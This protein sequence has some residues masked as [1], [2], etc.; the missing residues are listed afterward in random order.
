MNN[1]FDQLDKKNADELE[2]INSANIMA[3]LNK[4]I[5]L[6]KQD[7]LYDKYNVTLPEASGMREPASTLM[8]PPQQVAS[9]LT[10]NSVN[11]F[12][13]KRKLDEISSSVNTF[14]KPEGNPTPHPTMGGQKSTNTS[15]F[16]A[17]SHLHQTGEMEISDDFQ[18]AVD[19]SR[20]EIDTSSAAVETQNIEQPLKSLQKEA[21]DDW[22]KIK[23]MQ[24]SV[25]PSRDALKVDH[26]Q[27]LQSLDYSLPLN[28]D[29][30]LSFYW[31]DAHEE[32]NGLDLYL[33]G[34]IYQ[35]E[36][37]S[38]VSCALKINGMQREIYALPKTKGKA[39]SALTK[40]E[41]DKQVM[42]IY[43]ELDDIR[44]RKYPQITKWRCKPVTRKYAFEMPIQHGEHRFLK[45]KYDCTMP[46]LPQGM[47]GNTF[48]CLFGA[49]QS[50]LELFILKRK[51][52]GPCWITV[53]NPQKILDV[54]KT[55]CRQEI[56]IADPKQVEVTIDDLN[57]TDAPALS[58]ICFSFKTT[59]SQHN[60]NEIAMIS[61]L[62]HN[63]VSQ[64]GP[65]QLE[66]QFQTLTLLRKLDAKP[67]PFDF[68]KRI[69]ERKDVQFFAG[70]RQMI[71][72]FINRLT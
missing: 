59:R 68:E 11:P 26:T 12:S 35:P 1:L 22:Q 63:N 70:E 17:N 49:G 6:N 55:W 64:D 8:G 37:K 36:V 46:S 62:I 30:T 39:R 53:K 38:F 29:G 31:F 57:R 66:K 41:E 42:N 24:Q 43:T 69:R 18:S 54:K 20:M 2:D 25:E 71:E 56:Q 3:D 65:T 15:Y 10:H 47:T 5:A 4:T 19:D 21:S 33:F 51:I 13:K 32:N 16:D 23:Q 45:I 52:K 48:E 58:S 67:M 61:C 28:K 50:M 27:T 40:E 72:A 9:G 14:S 44:K 34:K 60:T 7:Q